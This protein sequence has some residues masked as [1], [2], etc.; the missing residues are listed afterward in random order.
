MVRLYNVTDAVAVTGSD[1]TVSTT[2]PQRLTADR[3]AV[4][5]GTKVYRA[6]AQKGTTWIEVWGVKLVIS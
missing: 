6:E 3:L 2:L 4:P 5:A 1:I